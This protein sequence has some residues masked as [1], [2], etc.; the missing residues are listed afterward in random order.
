MDG[1]AA[2]IPQEFLDRLVALERQIRELKEE[3]RQLREQLDESKRVAAR[4][5][6][7]FRR[8]D[9]QKIPDGQKKKPGRPKGHE[10]SY[11][12]VPKQV[13]ETAEAPLAGC[14]NCG[15]PVTDV[16]PIEQFIEEIPVMRPRVTRL[17][18]YQGSCATCG[19]VCSNHPLQTSTAIGAAKTQLGPRARALAI[20]LRQRCG[21]T[22]R[23][24]C[25]VLQSLTGLRLTAG[26]LALAIQRTARRVRPSL[27]Q[28]INDIRNS[29][30]AF[31]DETS[32]YVGA[33]AHWL[34]AI[35]TTDSTMYHVDSSRGRQVVLDML[36][37]SFRGIVV[38]DCL[39]S[40]EGLPYRTHKCVAHHEKAISEARARPDSTDQ[41]HLHQ[42]KLLFMMVRTLWRHRGRLGEEEFAR[43]KSHLCNWLN[44]LLVE[45]RTQRGDIA[46]QKRIGKRRDVV[47]G[48]LDDPAAEPTN[49]RAERALRPAVIARKLSCGNR[50][51]RGKDAW[52]TLTSL[53]TTC[54]QRRHDFVAWLA[55]CLPLAAAV[56]PIP[57]AH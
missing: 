54:D 38:S 3:N 45:P 16:A 20:F 39:A 23:N 41:S 42:W 31:I 13:D 15:G 11:R 6:A 12:V 37:N 2:H 35:T 9:S 14:P 29:K 47:L 40:Y 4:Q 1:T 18:T 34:W 19:D 57:P 55:G 51:E 7:P 8:R 22:M 33:P 17:V 49:N 56:T 30:A 21:L 26:G 24:T 25:R 10:G 46:I 36:G 44:R 43:Q 48:C 27:D 5:A 50:T 32:W 52:Q 53:A 28:L